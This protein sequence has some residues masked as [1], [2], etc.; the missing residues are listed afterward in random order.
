MAHSINTES[1]IL[2]VDDLLGAPSK[3]QVLAAEKFITSFPST[4]AAL[5]AMV[6]AL[7]IMEANHAVT[8]ESICES[9]AE[10]EITSL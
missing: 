5:V 1:E 2:T 7:R 8:L 4:T 6:A 10:V 3:A 9:V